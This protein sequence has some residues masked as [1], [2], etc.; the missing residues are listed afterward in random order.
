MK[1]SATKKPVGRAQEI[2]PHKK[3]KKRYDP[4][5]FAVLSPDEAK[6]WLSERALPGETPTG[7]PL[8]AASLL[9]QDGTGEPRSIPGGAKVGRTKKGA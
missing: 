1:S 8:T 9:E 3:Q 7:Q 5:R 2:E 6:L 4:P